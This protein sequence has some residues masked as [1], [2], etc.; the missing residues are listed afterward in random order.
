VKDNRNFDLLVDV[1]R[2][3]KKYGPDAFEH[4]AEDL[5]SPE[6]L[7]R[8]IFI[9]RT[10]AKA[11]KSVKADKSPRGKKHSSAD[12]RASLASIEDKEK[13]DLLLKFY[14]DLMAK[15]TLPTLRSLQ[16]F[17]SDAGLPPFKAKLRDKAV[18]QVVKNLSALPLDELKSVLSTIRQTPSQDDRSLEGWSNIILN[19]KHLS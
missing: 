11:G 1:A 4:L 14:D 17:V 12:F 8:L 19:K 18:A 5:S 2:L 13:S 9:L 7:D 16:S 10:T 15:T 6:L 3:L